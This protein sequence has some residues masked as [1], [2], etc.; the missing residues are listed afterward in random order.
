[1]ARPAVDVVVPFCGRASALQQLQARLERLRRGPGDTLLIVDNTPRRDGTDRARTM[2]HTR[3]AI[4]VLRDARR[5]T[6]GYARNRGAAVGNAE[7]LVFLDADT[8]PGEDLLDRYFEPEPGDATGLIGGGIRDEPV[9]G[10]GRPAA[11]YQYMRAAMSQDQTF[12]LGPWGF[13]VT[14]N[15]AVRRAAF[16]RVGGFREDIRAAEDADLTFRLRA[17]GWRVERRDDAVVTHRSRQTLRAFVVQQALHA[18]GGAWLD[19]HYPGSTPPRSG[20]GVNWG[21]VR[22][23]SEGLIAAAR[24][25]ERDRLVWAVFEPLEMLSWKLGR[26]LPNERPLGRW[27]ASRRRG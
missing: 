23:A 27:L 22:E 9:A 18:A 14:A 4:P 16:E 6:P 13:P 11:R 5:R 8:N 7:W 3:D 17:D 10:N 25:G 21:R 2:Q 20:R 26:S 1:M 12:R 24:S 15:V 19:R